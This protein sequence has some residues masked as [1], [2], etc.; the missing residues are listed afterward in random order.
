[1]NNHPRILI[2]LVNF[3]SIEDSV[4]FLENFSNFPNQE[5]TTLIFHDNDSKICTSENK[6]IFQEAAKRL[7]L[8]INI[9]F[10]SCAQNLGYLGGFRYAL[11]H[12]DIAVEDYDFICLS[13]PDI[14]FD[15]NK[16]STSL[17]P[18]KSD[19]YAIIAP[20]IVSK[21]SGHEQNPYLS[22][23]P[24]RIKVIFFSILFK[25]SLATGIY[26]LLMSKVRKS[27]STGRIRATSTSPRDIYAGHGS[28]VIFTRTFFSR[29]VSLS[30]SNFLFCEENY[31]GH[32]VQESKLKTLYA[33]DIEVMHRE[34]SSTK[35][36][37]SK[38]I[39]THLADAHATAAKQYY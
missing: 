29:K 21:L 25:S 5:N 38:T 37:P 14:E 27:L 13:N 4:L 19:T 11:T 28:F 1:M 20:R 15:S 16:L 32:K 23:K 10:S 39:C 36:F 34:H 8:N 18:K 33:P 24:P 9:L 7:N 35:I 31:L 3:N 30:M 2:C 26:R 17:A 12:D 6:K 22:K